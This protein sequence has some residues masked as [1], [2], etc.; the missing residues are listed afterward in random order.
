MT[1][2]EAVLSDGIKLQTWRKGLKFGL[3]IATI[4][5]NPE[6]MDTDILKI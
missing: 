3:K 2:S 6:A 5:K 1:A 4:S